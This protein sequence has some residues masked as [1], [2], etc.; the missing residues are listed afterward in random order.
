M[1]FRWCRVNAPWNRGSW[2]LPAVRASPC[3]RTIKRRSLM[4]NLFLAEWM[5]TRKRPANRVL[6]FL[7]LGILLIVFAT[8]TIVAWHEAGEN[9]STSAQQMMSF[10]QGFRLP[11]LVLSALGSLIGIVFMA[12]SVGSEYSRDTWKALLPR[13]GNRRDFI[14]GKL[15]ASLCFMLGLIVIT[16]LLGQ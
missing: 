2:K 9:P 12:N 5:K 6:V 11:L 1:S 14:L 3:N 10:P 7:V 15:A 16:L 13:R 8:T 4:W